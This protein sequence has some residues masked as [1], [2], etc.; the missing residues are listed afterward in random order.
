MDLPIVSVEQHGVTSCTCVVNGVRAC[1][2]DGRGTDD[3][4]ADRSSNRLESN[5]KMLQNFDVHDTCSLLGGARSEPLEE[6]HGVAGKHVEVVGR[7]LVA[8]VQQNP[9][10]RDHGLRAHA[11]SEC[12][13]VQIET[14]ALGEHIARAGPARRST[15]RPWLW[16]TTAARSRRRSSRLR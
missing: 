15:A 3:W 8:L 13:R 2:Q 16:S 9:D 14:A 7:N 10:L 1:D 12:P 6:I 4:T 5:F 11:R